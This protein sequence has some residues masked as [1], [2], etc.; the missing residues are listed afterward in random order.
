MLSDFILKCYEISRTKVKSKY[1]TLQRIIFLLRQIFCRKIISL[2]LSALTDFLFR[3]LGP[4]IGFSWNPQLS[5]IQFN[6]IPKAGAPSPFLFSF[7][8]IFISSITFRF[9]YIVF[10]TLQGGKILT[11]YRSQN[12]PNLRRYIPEH[13]IYL[14]YELFERKSSTLKVRE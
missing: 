10:S 11:H 13:G 3:P 14:F 2:Q 6:P 5:F 4:E 9:L 12:L 1:F 7:S 8:F